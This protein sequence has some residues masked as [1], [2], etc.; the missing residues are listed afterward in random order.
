MECFVSGMSSVLERRNGQRQVCRKKEVVMSNAGC[1]ENSERR[2]M[3]GALAGLMVMGVSG[4]AAAS[5]MSP[6]DTSLLRICECE[7]VMKP[8]RKYIAKGEWDRAR[9]NINYCTRNLR[10]KTNMKI[11]SEIMDDP[12][13]GIEIMAD[14]ENVFTQMDASVYT[15]IFIPSDEGISPEQEKYQKQAFLYYEQAMRMLGDYLALVPQD[16]KV[17]AFRE[18]AKRSIFEI[19]VED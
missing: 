16:K 17:G 8:V 3:L 15:P 14:L 19:K 11:F 9:T 2:M 18:A 1:E 13:E 5:K 6:I 7:R 12:L 10:L 4:P